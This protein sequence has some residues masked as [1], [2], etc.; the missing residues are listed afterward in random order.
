MNANKTSFRWSACHAGGH[1]TTEQ[2]RMRS[3]PSGSAQLCGAP[4][5]PAVRRHAK[6]GRWRHGKLGRPRCNELPRRG[7]GRPARQRAG[8]QHG[9]RAQGRG[10]SRRRPSGWRFARCPPKSPG[11]CPGGA[12]PGIRRPVAR[13]CHASSFRRPPHAAFAAAAAASAAIS[14]SMASRDAGVSAS[15]G[16]TGPV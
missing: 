11:A 5:L 4:A 7:G 1:E 12:C 3:A 9:R 2:A 16:P 8:L 15:G 14:A 10:A 6:L 13:V